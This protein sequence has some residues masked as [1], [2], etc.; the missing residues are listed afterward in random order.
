V[1]FVGRPAEVG[2][3]VPLRARVL[4]PTLCAFTAVDPIP[5]AE[6]SHALASSYGYSLLNPA[7]LTDPTGKSAAVLVTQL[8]TAIEFG[9]VLAQVVGWIVSTVSSFLAAIPLWGWIAI[10]LLAVLAIAIVAKYEDIYE[11]GKRALAKQLDADRRLRMG[12]L[13]PPL[14]PPPEDQCYWLYKKYANET[15]IA[16]KLFY[17]AIYAWHC[18]PGTMFG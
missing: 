4:A 13:T 9:A 14:I 17:G 18:G 11:K 7:L 3:M 16:L 12:R 6:G 8:P 5:P 15:N 10:A 1:G 2:G